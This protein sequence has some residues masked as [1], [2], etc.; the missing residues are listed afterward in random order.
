MK[1][2]EHI[3]FL[4]LDAGMSD[5]M[6]P[7]LYQAYHHVDNISS[8]SDQ[9]ETYDVV[10]PI[11]E[12]SD[13]FQ[14]NFKLPL[15]KRGDLMAIRSVGAYGETMKNHYNARDFAPPVYSSDLK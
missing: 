6:R 2:S 11:C 1:E 7:S 15:S 8:D 12:T 10:G 9:E 4:I 13:S 3:K 5:L 14:R